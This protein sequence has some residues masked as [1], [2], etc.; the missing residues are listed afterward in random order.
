[1]KWYILIVILLIALAVFLD[2]RDRLVVDETRSEV[3]L[4]APSDMMMSRDIQ[5]AAKV[6]NLQWGAWR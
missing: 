3:P 6:E 1:M 2:A 4:F 5:P